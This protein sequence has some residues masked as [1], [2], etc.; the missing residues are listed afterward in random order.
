VCFLM[1]RDMTRLE[2]LFVG[3]S[4]GAAVAGAIK[5]ARTME[6]KATPS[7]PPLKILVFLCDAGQK[8]VSKIFNDDWMRENGFLEDQVGLGVVADILNMGGKDQSGKDQR[9]IV[10]ASPESKVRDVIDILK[11][12]GISQ[13]PVVEGGKLRGIVAEID[14]LRHLVS[15]QKTLDS[16]IREIVE[17]DYATVTPATKIELLQGVLAESKAAIVLSG[18]EVVGIVTQID[19]IDYLARF[20]PVP[21]GATGA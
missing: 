6:A 10:T 12:R 19:L 1:T 13:L 17:S 11:S 5:Y 7:S 9:R 21:S 14:I 8:Y 4:G 16:P 20:N 15:R 3:G 18:D 2:G